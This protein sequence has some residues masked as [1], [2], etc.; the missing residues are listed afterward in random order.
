MHGAHHKNEDIVGW[1]EIKSVVRNK[2]NT[3]LKKGVEV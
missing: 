1:E 3:T 2:K